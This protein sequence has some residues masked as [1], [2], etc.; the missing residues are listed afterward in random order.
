[1]VLGPDSVLTS[2]Q[3]IIVYDG[4][5]A[6]PDRLTQRAH[7]HY[8]DYARRMLAVYQHGV[9][10]TRRELHRS[11]E[12]IL[13]NE[14]DCDTRRIQA[15]CKLLDEAGE[16]DTDRRGNAAKLRLAVFDLA[17]P[18]HPLV[19][20]RDQLFENTESEAKAHIAQRLGRPWPEIEGELYA[21][22]MDF[23]RLTAFE[24]YSNAAALLRRYNVA[25]LQAALYRAERLVIAASED[26]KTILRYAKLAQLLHDIRRLPPLQPPSLSG[27]GNGEGGAPVLAAKSH[28][29]PTLA[30]EGRGVKAPF[31]PLPGGEREGTNVPL[32]DRS[33]HCQQWAP[34]G[35]GYVIELSGP[36]SVLRETRRYGINFA[37][38]LPALLACDGWAMQATLRTPWGGKAL[39]ALSSRDGL[40]ST[41]PPPEEFDS[42]VEEGFA[43]KFGAERDGWR[44][45]RE[46]EV[47]VEGQSVFVPDFAFRHGDGTEVLL[48][49]VGFWTPEYLEKKRATLRRFRG[50]R[51]YLAVAERCLPE[52]ATVSEDVVVYKT[53]LKVEPVLAL[54]E[55][56][57]RREAPMTNDQ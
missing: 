7:A 14:P 45:G 56:A 19:E 33:A 41:M 21:D 24:G 39:L 47:L 51:V 48:E 18:L 52:G 49:I 10:Q 37:R 27:R 11:V 44:L 15:F 28:P 30:L 31:A 22:V 16:F 20:S 8:L 57:R 23:H 50:R 34:D 53:A 35:C 54:L 3:S 40:Q 13:A 1:M 36:A 26:F 32:A 4:G 25:Q 17:A 9:G 6:W 5:R 46:G 43:A 29:H 2:E 12:G 42:S 38:F 55:R